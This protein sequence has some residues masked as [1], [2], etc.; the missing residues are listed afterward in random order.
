MYS[1]MD[2]GMGM[3][4]SDQNSKFYNSGQS[5]QGQINSPDVNNV[6]LNNMSN[7][8]N[9]SNLTNMTNMGNYGVYNNQK[10]N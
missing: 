7:M 1:N 5:E 2:S 9:M 4:M 10:S 6:N 3:S 8:N